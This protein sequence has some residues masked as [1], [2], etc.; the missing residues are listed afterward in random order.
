M[1][2][3]EWHERV[4]WANFLEENV[5][6]KSLD[7]A[8]VQ[9]EHGIGDDKRIFRLTDFFAFDKNTM[10]LATLELERLDGLM[11]AGRAIPMIPDDNAGEDDKE[12]G[13]DYEVEVRLSAVTKVEYTYLDVSAAEQDGIYILTSFA[14]Y[15]LE[16]PAGFYRISYQEPFR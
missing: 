15:L 1:D 6:I 12:R 14:W 3:D 2:T 5:V 9:A 11:I 13:E 16:R 10:K 4:D 8:D 7:D